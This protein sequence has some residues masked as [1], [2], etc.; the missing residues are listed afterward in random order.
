ME[1][2][3]I[4][5][6]DGKG[7]KLS[8]A[9]E[10]EIQFLIENGARLVKPTGAGVG[11]I[12]RIRRAKDDY[13]AFLCGNAAGSFS[14]FKVALDCANGSASAF[15]PRV[16]RELGAQVFSFADEPDGTNINDRCGSTHPERL[17]ERMREE[18]ADVG[19]AFDGDADRLIAVDEYGNLVDGDRIMG[20]CA[21]AMKEAGTLKN[22][23]LVTTVM[24]NLGLKKTM[25]AAGIKIEETQVGDR[26]VLECM[27]QNGFNLGGEQSGHM[28]F[29]DNNTTGDGILSAVQL[30]N[31]LKKSGKRLSALAGQIPIYP[32]VL[33]N[34][35]VNDNRAAMEDATLKARIEQV[36]SELAD[37]GRV[38]VRAS[39][40]EPLVRIM[41]EGQDEDMLRMYAISMADILK[42][43]YDG[44]IKM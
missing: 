42:E 26:Y 22:D 30:L 29:L 40:T 43:K 8:D 23:T 34:V 1:Y 27:R 9:L 37:T 39:G 18:D 15:A 6:F 32:Q 4:K 25:Q 17:Q 35:I 31:V 21:L 28:I 5:W 38:L 24:S 16:F 12:S 11:H 3:G 20:I 33:V 36:E 41:L 14:G 19:F 10:D 13:T 7:L 44:R 2:N